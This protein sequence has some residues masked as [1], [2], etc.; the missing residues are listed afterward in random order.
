MWGAFYYFNN[1]PQ[2]IDSLLPSAKQQTNI[3][4][5]VV[6]EKSEKSIERHEE[7]TII[8]L[9]KRVLVPKTIPDLQD[10]NISRTQQQLV[11]DLSSGTEDEQ[12]EALKLLSK[13]GKPE[14]KEVIKEYAL[15][16][17]EE[18]PVRLAA[19]EN[20]DWEQNTDVIKNL[21][22]ANNEVSEA[23]IYMANSK[24]LSNEAQASIDDAVYSASF[25]SPKPSTQIAILNY[26]L[27]RHSSLFDDVA[28]RVSFDGFL[29]QER[30]EVEQLLQ[31][32]REEDALLNN[33]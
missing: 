21:I 3:P 22:T 33:N 9:P 1:Q 12:I 31:K 13:I 16:P 25:Q 23:A 28:A 4:H 30:E 20:I 17:S 19:V 8:A 14:Q 6:S 26:L 11:Y 18:I 24:E 27:E 29:L 32:R 15:N 10:D 5:E 7:L 2:P